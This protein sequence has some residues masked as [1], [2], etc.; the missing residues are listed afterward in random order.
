[1]TIFDFE[2][3]Q[4]FSAR[5]SRE[6]FWE[7]AYREAFPSFLSMSALNVG[8]NT[9][10][11]SGIDR[12]I[13]L[14]SGQVLTVDEKNLNRPFDGHVV[15]EYLSNDRT[16]T[17]GWI[18]KDLP[19]D[20]LGYGFVENRRVLFFPFQQLRAAWLRHRDTWKGWAEESYGGWRHITAQNS[21]YRTHSV[22]APAEAVYEAVQGALAVRVP[23]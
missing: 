2:R 17:P 12:W 19:M 10:N 14:S 8:D 9:A 3:C 13:H 23:V 21:N 1:M 20:Y 11:R 18:E 22:L 15:L 6:P 5:A 7:A 16:G 4:Q